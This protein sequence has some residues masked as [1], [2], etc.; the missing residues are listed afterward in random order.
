MDG[1]V[2]AKQ[3]AGV[4]D[5]SHRVSQRIKE[6]LKE[7]E[8]LSPESRIDAINQIKLALQNHS[9]FSHEPIDCVIWLKAEQ[10]QANDYNP[11]NVAPPEMKLLEVSI[12]EDGFTQPIV[13]WKNENKYEV[14]DGFHRNLVGRG[15][16][17]LRQRL[18]GYLPIVVINRDRQE[19]SDR[20]AA[21]IRHNRAR[22]RHNVDIMSE[23]VVE[24]K[25]RNRSD[26]W[27]AEHL[28]MD[29]DE[30]LRLTQISG[31]MSMFAN[32]EF[33][34]AWDVEAEPGGELD[35]FLTGRKSGRKSGQ[36]T[37]R[38]K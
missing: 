6:A 25:G 35:P 26:K 9:P 22:G 33:S 30:V 4:N 34:R 24:M 37:G 14:V 18:R 23:I 36:K 10:V 2:H 27:I 17:T 1:I 20:M 5:K 15:S 12:R 13:T 32:A 7:L 8:T 3:G 19:R 31:L 21:T 29:E 16:E 11:N 38:K 28:G